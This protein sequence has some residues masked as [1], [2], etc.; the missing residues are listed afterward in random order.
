MIVNILL[1]LSIGINIVLLYGIFN[2]V[3]KSEAIEDLMVDTLRDTK[4]HITNALLVMQNSDIKG[5]FE[6][7]DE[8][9]VAFKDIKTAIEELNEKF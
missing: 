1:G 3:R 9:G 6:A 8:V 2:L 5:S 4:E 7:D